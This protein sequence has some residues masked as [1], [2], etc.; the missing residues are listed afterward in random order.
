MSV[1]VYSM[2]SV[3]RILK[4]SILDKSLVCTSS[5]NGSD[6]VKDEIVKA[7]AVRVGKM[8]KMLICVRLPVQILL[9]K[10]TREVRASK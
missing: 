1:I 5:K 8:F 9:E 3:E 4:I 7:R 10:L 6:F 2:H